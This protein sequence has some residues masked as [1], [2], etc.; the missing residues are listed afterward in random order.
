MRIRSRSRDGGQG[1]N[2]SRSNMNLKQCIIHRLNR[3]PA[4][5]LVWVV[6][7]LLQLTPMRSHAAGLQ[8]DVFPGYGDVLRQHHW[9]PFTFELHHEGPGFS[10]FIR[11]RDP[12]SNF[13]QSIPIELPTNTRKRVVMPVY[14][15]GGNIYNWVAELVTTSGD[16]VEERSQF[17]GQQ[18]V[19]P[20]GFVLGSVSRNISGQPDLPKEPDRSPFLPL[21][22]RIMTEHFP[23][24]PLALEGLNAIYLH[25]AAAGKMEIPQARALNAWLAQG[26]HLIVAIDEPAEITAVPWLGSLIPFVPTGVASIT[27][28]GTLEKWIRDPS[29]KTYPDATC[30]PDLIDKNQNRQFNTRSASIDNRYTRIRSDDEIEA[31]PIPIVL[32]R[33][34]DGAVLAEQEGYPLIIHGVRGRGQVTVLTFS[35]EREPIKSWENKPWF[36]AKLSGI[37]GR[38]FEVGNRN[39]YAGEGVDGLFGSMIESRQ[40][41]KLPIEWLMLMLVVYLLFIGPIDRIILK[42][43]NRQMWTWITFPAYVALFSGLIYYIGFKL[44]AGDS[45]WNELHV[46]DVIPFGQESMVR[47]RTYGTLYSPVTAQYELKSQ[48]TLGSLRMEATGLWR[49]SQGGNRQS[50]LLKMG[51]GF[52]AGVSVPVWTSRLFISDWYDTY[53]N[54]IIEAQL[55]SNGESAELTA[56]N[57]VPYAFQHLR[58][59]VG[60]RVYELNGLAKAPSASQT[61]QLSQTKSISLPE[62]L[63]KHSSQFRAAL[64]SRLRALGHTYRL[65]NPFEAASVISMMGRVYKTTGNGQ[66]FVHQSNIDLTRHLENDKAVLLAW[67]ESDL[68]MQALNTFDPKRSSKKTLIRVLIPLKQPSENPQP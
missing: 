49:G 36:W 17:S 50:E 66:N 4:F 41:R 40:I 2:E 27:W 62:F 8:F 5:R 10:G 53:Q 67:S 60:D 33:V 44:R 64:D 48:R 52:A 28:D 45:E 1:K 16:V 31:A 23:D 24:Q 47:G 12:G 20:S 37:P 13:S 54:G 35:P 15:Q 3:F 55:S 7:F 21:V 19:T 38:W 59:M 57:L 9:C 43:L 14:Y 26:G 25:A 22:G 6:L 51:D 39:S 32:G 68:G 11:L 46:V 34:T 61:F 30:D 29:E 18:E 65:N 42:K 56:R 63:S 58:L